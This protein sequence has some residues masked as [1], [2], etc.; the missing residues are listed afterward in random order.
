MYPVNLEEYEVSLGV[1][2]G[3]KRNQEAIKL[4]K[5]D[6]FGFNGSQEEG[7][8]IHI[9]GACG[10]IALAKFMNWFYSGS[11]NT[12]KDGGDVGKIQVRTRSRDD[13]DLIVRKNDKDSDIFVLVT[14]ERPSYKIHGWIK[15]GDAKKEIF[16][17]NYGRRSPAYFV[18]QEFLL[19][20]S[21]LYKKIAMENLTSIKKQLSAPLLQLH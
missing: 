19:K 14:G 15:A 5:K 1:F 7:L 6:S 3:T 9:E 17:K 12:Y 18:P 13:Y 8:N 16:L 20:I 2:V 21:D 11:V 10:E 4:G